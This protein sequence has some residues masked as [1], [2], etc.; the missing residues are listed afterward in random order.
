MMT[1]KP[2]KAR[3]TPAIAASASRGNTRHPWHKPAA[4]EQMPPVKPK[5]LPEERQSRT[6]DRLKTVRLRV[7]I[8]RELDERGISTPAEI[9]SAL[10]M[11]PAAAAKLLT[12]RQW[13]EGDVALL[14]AVAAK[15]G[16]QAPEP[17]RD[18]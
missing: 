7:A 2:L 3:A 6:A 11:P 17:T 15:L 14:E 5:L 12:R 13:R 1:T 9:G 4:L 10:G 16:V 8:G 18:D